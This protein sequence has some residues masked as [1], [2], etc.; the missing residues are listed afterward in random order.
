MIVA[1]AMHSHIFPIYQNSNCFLHQQKKPTKCTNPPK[2]HHHHNRM[3][4]NLIADLAVRWHARDNAVLTCWSCVPRQVAVHVSRRCGQDCAAQ[5]GPRGRSVAGR[6]A[7]V[8]LL[9]ES[10]LGLASSW[11]GRHWSWTQGAVSPWRF[12]FYS[13]ASCYI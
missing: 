9:N 4:R 11:R 8:L 2:N 1:M 10:R 6:V 5:C 13:V 12:L 3:E 7:R